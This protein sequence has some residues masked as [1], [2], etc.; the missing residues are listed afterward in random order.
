MGGGWARIL[1]AHGRPGVRSS[2]GAPTHR[3]RDRSFV[4]RLRGQRRFRDVHR[5]GVRSRRN[6]RRGRF[7]CSWSRR[8]RRGRGGWFGCGRGRWLECR[9]RRFCVG[10]V[11]NHRRDARRAAS[12][13][14]LVL[15]RR[16][17]RTEPRSERRLYEVRIEVRA[18]QLLHAEHHVHRRHQLR[19][20]PS[21]RP[22]GPMPHRLRDR[23]RLSYAARGRADI[24]Q[25]GRHRD[26]RVSAVSVISPASGVGRLDRT[27]MLNPRVL[28]SK[29]T[30]WVSVSVLRRR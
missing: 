1:S 11:R 2:C 16:F 4:D 19:R 10:R 17:A 22:R 5:R 18:V 12:V 30:V 9:S 29:G 26:A 3:S 7:G 13:L 8:H 20:G 23:L 6:G 14:R 15:V 27:T 24:V 21:V 28:R 25:T